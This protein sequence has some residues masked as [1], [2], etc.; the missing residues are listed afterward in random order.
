MATTLG[1]E[2]KAPQVNPKVVSSKSKSGRMSL[3]RQRENQHISEHMVSNKLTGNFV[4]KFGEPASVIPAAER[5]P[6][7]IPKVD[8]KITWM[9]ATKEF[10]DDSDQEI[11]AGT[12]LTDTPM[13]LPAKGTAPLV[14]VPGPS[15]ASISSGIEEEPMR[16]DTSSN[17]VSDSSKFYETE[18]TPQVR[19]PQGHTFFR[20][21]GIH[22]PE[23]P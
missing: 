8:P 18:S 20:C 12:G 23:V 2:N 17:D 9:A 1:S 13:P 6:L 3:A 11:I 5:A 7:P 19:T 21:D 16:S 22:D 15:S 10:P 4:K 14:A